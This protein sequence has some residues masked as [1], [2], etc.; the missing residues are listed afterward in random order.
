MTVLNLSM[1]RNNSPWPITLPAPFAG[2]LGAG[3]Q[4]LTRY[5][6]ARSRFLLDGGNFA[7][8]QKGHIRELVVTTVQ[9]TN[10]SEADISPKSPPR[11]IFFGYA[12]TPDDDPL[13]LQWRVPGGLANSVK[14]AQLQPGAARAT[15]TVRT[16][17]TGG[18]NF[19]TFTRFI[20]FQV[21]ADGTIAGTSVVQTLGVNTETDAATNI[22]V[23]VNSTEIVVEVVGLAGQV[24]QWAASLELS[25][26]IGY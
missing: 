2:I 9:R 5:G 24:M 6:A 21:L 26:V 22:V 11:D 18:S 12:T 10:P 23:T 20:D 25:T 19:S 16:A 15:L 1:V 3:E 17:Q 4:I 13:R 14:A 8:D 7:P